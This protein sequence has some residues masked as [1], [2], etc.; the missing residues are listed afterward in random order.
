MNPERWKQVRQVLEEVLSHPETQRQDLLRSLCGDDSDLLAEVHTLLEA[1]ARAGSALEQRTLDVQAV[2]AKLSRVGQCLGPYRID[3]RIGAGGMGEVYRATR[4]EGG[5]EQRVAIKTIRPTFRQSGLDARFETERQVLAD[6]EHPNITRLLDGGTTADGSPYFVMELVE[7]QPLDEYCDEH[8]L[9]TRERVELLTLVCDAVCFAHQR[10]V[11]HRDLKPGNVLV[12][13]E[14]HPKLLDFGLVKVLA[15]DDHQG[16]LT[17]IHAFTPRYASPEQVHG[18]AVTPAA[19]VYALGTVLFE[20]L[21][22]CT[23]ERLAT[24]QI[25]ASE[26]RP[27]ASAA[28]SELRADDDS[29]RRDSIAS[30][31]GTTIG[32][33]ATTLRGDLDAIV[34]TATR[35]A[36]RERYADAG[37]LADDLRA[38]L[39][40]R[41]VAARSKERAYRARRFIRHYGPATALTTAIAATALWWFGATEGPVFENVPG[42]LTPLITWPSS[43]DAPQF[44]PDGSRVAFVSDRDGQPAIWV[45]DLDGSDV[46]RIPRDR[47]PAQL[48]WAPTGDA[49]VALEGTEISGQLLLVGLDLEGRELW[50]H[51]WSAPGEITGWLDDGIHLIGPDGASR[52][53]PRRGAIETLTRDGPLIGALNGEVHPRTRRVV[54]AVPTTDRSEDLWVSDLDGSN[55]SRLTQTSTREWAPQWT[56][57]AGERIAFISN[58]SGQIDLWEMDIPSGE[59]RALTLNFEREDSF[60]VL[61]DTGSIVVATVREE[62]NLVRLDIESGTESQLTSDLQLDLFP[63]ATSGGRLFAHRTVPL[64]TGLGFR[65][66]NT[67][68]IAFET[69]DPQPGN[70]PEKVA[71]GHRALPSPDGKLV[72]FSRMPDGSRRE[73][74]WVKPLDQ[75]GP[76]LITSL[77]QPVNFKLLPLG[78]WHRSYTWDADNQLYYVVH[79]DEAWGINRWDPEHPG[80]SLTAVRT[81]EEPGDPTIRA[82]G[83]LAYHA[84][85]G[86]HVVAP[87]APARTLWES[88][89]GTRLR[90]LAWRGD[91]LLAAQQ[92]DGSGALEFLALAPD[93]ASRSL[94]VV[95]SSTTTSIAL[96]KGARRAIVTANASGIHNLWVVDLDTGQLRQ[97]TR[98]RLR[99]AGYSAPVAISDSAVVATRQ[100]EGWDIWLIQD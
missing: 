29:S 74:L 93:G 80:T 72:A 38:Y 65:Q 86:V 24:A 25:D 89:P 33:L 47:R 81:A 9:S 16:S 61:L 55:A 54:F 96:L 75:S 52:M 50:A 18:E 12:T 17:T 46:Q 19:D 90:V 36:A 77:L 56:D 83:W 5:F 42:T 6:L 40:D 4:I 92:R 35:P 98:N 88:T 99:S 28:V 94:A 73:E 39:Q 69:T 43:E 41:P 100:H 13:A 37:G 10:G 66:M 68:I 49:L 14:G 58:R 20:I 79:D 70:V 15:G 53:S 11:V 48:H 87:G 7:G 59:A 34:S 23:A 85:T 63:Q 71:R 44:S 82:D 64:L 21:T 27:R 31:H 30:T 22:G 2:A 32:G 97:A 76:R 60:D 95:P 51:A 8:Q 45:Q 3:E 67:E 84:G 78:W 62:G 91:E 57:S 1:D 26:I